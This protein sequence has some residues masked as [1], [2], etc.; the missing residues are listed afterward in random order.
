MSEQTQPITG[1]QPD[2]AP[3]EAPQEPTSEAAQVADSTES[4][5]HTESTETVGTRT[6]TDSLAAPDTTAQAAQ[7]GSDQDSDEA[8]QTQE[9]SAPALLRLRSPPAPCRPGPLSLP[10]RPQHLRHSPRGR[11]APR[12]RRARV[13]RV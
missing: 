5:E 7:D 13:R 8:P 1:L 2:T 9:A 4:T 6:G 3:S 10:R 11:T 12:A